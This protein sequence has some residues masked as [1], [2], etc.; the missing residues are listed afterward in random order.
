M[1][2]PR[3]SPEDNQLSAPHHLREPRGRVVLSLI[4]NRCT[5]SSS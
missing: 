4:E 1:V 5:G 3:P 2:P